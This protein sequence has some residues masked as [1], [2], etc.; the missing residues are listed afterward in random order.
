[1][2]SVWNFS[3]KRARFVE[4]KSPNDQLSETQKIW[5]SVLK[6]ANVEI[7]VCRVDEV[8][9][10]KQS[11]LKRL[12]TRPTPDRPSK[13]RKTS[14]EMNRYYNLSLVNGSDQGESDEEDSDGPKLRGEGILLRRAE[15][16]DGWESSDG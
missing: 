15:I 10:P 7:E 3:E 9:D 11:S 2:S 16:D 12:M 8:S 5:I 1:M 4:V 14:E 6:A 13:R